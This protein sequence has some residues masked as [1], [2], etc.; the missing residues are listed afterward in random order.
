MG[1][2]EVREVTIEVIMPLNKSTYI[3]NNVQFKLF[4][5]QNDVA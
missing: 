2:E 3:L 4:Y 1:N 5:L